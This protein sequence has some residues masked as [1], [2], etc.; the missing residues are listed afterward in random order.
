M[1]LWKE[2]GTKVIWIVAPLFISLMVWLVVQTYNTQIQIAVIKKEA[3][4]RGQLT[5]KIYTLAADN[6]RMLVGKA[7]QVENDAAHKSIMNKMNSIEQKVDKLYWIHNLTNNQVE[8]K[9]E[10]RQDSITYFLT[11]YFKRTND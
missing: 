8:I 9:G 2:I 4:N 6:N 5:E 3:D 10:N 11:N 1:N 7:D